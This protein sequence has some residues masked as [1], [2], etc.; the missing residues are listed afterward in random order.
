MGQPREAPGSVA[1]GQGRVHVGV[2]DPS[3]TGKPGTQQVPNMCLGDD[4]VLAS[5]GA[6][7][8]SQGTWC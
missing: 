3:V 1:G 7:A 4:V 2:D 6:T 5:Q 8:Q